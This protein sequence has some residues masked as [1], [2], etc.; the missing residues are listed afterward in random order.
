MEA[1]L[2]FRFAL[3]AALVC[4][5]DVYAID[6]ELPR[7]SG[8]VVVDGQLDEVA[9][10]DAVQ[11]ELNF[12]TSPGENLPARAQTVAYLMED[13]KRLYVAVCLL[14]HGGI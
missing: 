11:V 1:T 6:I 8:A 14:Q 5:S 9:W 7:S 10:R 4:C 13:G 3:M 12:E 2:R